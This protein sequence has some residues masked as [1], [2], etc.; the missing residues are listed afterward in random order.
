MA[1]KM[2]EEDKGEED[3]LA[4]DC[5]LCRDCIS[6]GLLV[7]HGAIAACCAGYI[8]IVWLIS[9]IEPDFTL[10][11]AFLI[12][13]IVSF[14]MHCYM[15]WV[16]FKWNV[17]RSLWDSTLDTKQAWRIIAILVVACCVAYGM[18]VIFMM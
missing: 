6:Y 17:I 18:R 16:M 13:C 8:V 2:P 5:G 9:P 3:E 7:V 10:S 12:I 1:K 4:D 15:L 14:A 11:P